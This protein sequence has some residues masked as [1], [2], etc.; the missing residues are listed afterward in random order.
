M[1]AGETIGDS[2]LL[3][4]ACTTI[5][6]TCREAGVIPA[7]SRNCDRETDFMLRPRFELNRRS[8]KVLFRKSGTCPSENSRLTRGRQDAAIPQATTG[9]P[10][11]GLPRIVMITL[12]LGG[13]RSGKSELAE[14]M[15]AQSDEP[16]TY[17]ATGVATDEDMAARIEAHRV[18]RPESWSTIEA[19]GDLAGALAGVSGTV[20]LDALGT[21]LARLEGFRAD[22]AA[23]CAALSLRSG[24]TIVVSDEVGLGVHP[25]TSIGRDFRDALG[26]LNQSVSA[27]ADEV[28]LVVA[29]RVLPIEK[30]P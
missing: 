3:R 15:A 2:G 30:G 9:G 5:L 21:W 27:I 4:E 12:I 13:T 23:L 16:V 1:P 11:C 10:G 17:I 8:R 20:L 19:D 6:E 29:G 7:L 26:D 18:R 28:I 25:S 24:H 14:R 22:R